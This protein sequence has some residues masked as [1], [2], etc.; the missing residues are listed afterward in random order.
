MTAY[1]I[2]RVEVHDMDRYA[3]YMRHTPRVV[4]QYGGRIITRGA[5]PLTLEGEPETLRNHEQITRAW[6]KAAKQ[7]APN[8]HRAHDALR[9]SAL[10]KPQGSL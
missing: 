3:E 6:A 10:A 1:L 7:R 9:A 4:H 5:T 2:A 8:R